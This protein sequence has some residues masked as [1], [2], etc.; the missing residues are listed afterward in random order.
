[1]ADCEALVWRRDEGRAPSCHP[2]GE[3]RRRAPPGPEV[4]IGALIIT[5]LILRVPYFEGVY[6]G[7]IVGFYTIGAL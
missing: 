7:S 1:M 5:Y 2:H 4:T 3:A 6:K